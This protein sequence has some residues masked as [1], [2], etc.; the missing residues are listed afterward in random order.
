LGLV[1]SLMVLEEPPAL[2]ATS[3][4]SGC[5]HCHDGCIAQTD[6]RFRAH[7]TYRAILWPA[8]AQ[9]SWLS[10]GASVWTSA[11]L[12]DLWEGAQAKP[13]TVKASGVF[14]VELEPHASILYSAVLL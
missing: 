7:W 14:D 9:A 4:I 5:R 3:I 11:Q 12:R 13:P 1:A 2:C 6:T 10:E 8:L